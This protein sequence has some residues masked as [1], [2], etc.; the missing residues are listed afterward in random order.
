MKKLSLIL[1]LS[2]LSGNIFVAYG[3]LI[4]DF[5]DYSSFYRFNISPDGKYIVDFDEKFKVWSTEAHQLIKPLS[6]Y[7]NGYDI[8]RGYFSKD[9]R[10]YIWDYAASYI[11]NFETRKMNQL[12]MNKA[13]PAF[14]GLSIIGVHRPEGT[15]EYQFLKLP[16]G[17]TNTRSE[18]HTSELQSRENLVCRLLLEKKKNDRDN[19]SPVNEMKSW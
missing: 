10:F 18:E 6:V 4:K 1:L 5:N 19:S 7:S 11:Y 16:A 9:S 15:K 3:Q 8:K 14:D 2:V 12:L 17:A 13:R